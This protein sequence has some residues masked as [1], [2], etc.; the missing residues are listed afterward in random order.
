ME[1]QMLVYWFVIEV[2][3]NFSKY[4]LYCVCFVVS[5]C[6]FAIIIWV[7]YNNFMLR[8]VWSDLTPKGHE[9]LSY[10]FDVQQKKNENIWIQFIEFSEIPV[11][12]VGYIFYTID[13]H[14]WTWK[15][16][17]DYDYSAAPDTAAYL[18]SDLWQPLLTSV[19]TSQPALLK[20]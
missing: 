2:L 18:P 8:D 16:L 13:S 4:L 3:Y 12:L 19:G 1:V 6:L 7:Q 9:G 5:N 10:H 11:Q 17:D 14:I 20:R 15:L